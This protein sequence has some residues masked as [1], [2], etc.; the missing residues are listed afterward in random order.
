MRTGLNIVTASHR[1]SLANQEVL[2]L[3]RSV[4]ASLS[5]A[6][7]SL[8]RPKEGT[9]SR[10]VY[11]LLEAMDKPPAAALAAI[12]PY[13]DPGQALDVRIKGI[14]VLAVAETHAPQA[15]TKLD[16]ILFHPERF[17]KNRRDSSHI[18]WCA[19]DGLLALNDPGCVQ[20]LQTAF[21]KPEV[22]PWEQQVILYTLGR[23]SAALPAQELSQMIDRGLKNPQNFLP[24]VVDAIAL[25][26]P[27]SGRARAEWVGH[28]QAV[29]LARLELVGQ[30]DLPA[31]NHPLLVK[32][33]VVVLGRIGTSDAIAPLGSY[34]EGI[35][36]GK[37]PETQ[38]KNILKAGSRALDDLYRR[39]SSARTGNHKKPF[40]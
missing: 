19:A 11:D 6:D 29:V 7:R 5:P 12:S 35:K 4:Y 32:R 23:M 25:L 15:L 30:T 27:A 33:A 20:D 26:A 21:W 3:L 40:G 2:R 31:W 17:V 28:Y 37:L 39:A 22:K 18:R 8:A 1:N 38:K 16:E 13:L 36:T 14:V 24:R 34:L 9:R 10:Q